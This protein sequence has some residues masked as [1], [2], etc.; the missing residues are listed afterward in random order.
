MLVNEMNLRFFICSAFNLG[1]NFKY[2]LGNDTEQTE[3]TYKLNAC[4]KELI[5]TIEPNLGNCDLLN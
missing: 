2:L 5:E 3:N 4:N 1:P